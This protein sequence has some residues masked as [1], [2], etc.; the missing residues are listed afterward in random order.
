MLCMNAVNANT[1]K[2]RSKSEAV[3]VGENAPLHV[4]TID[5][6]WTRRSPDF[7]GYDCRR[8][9]RN[10]E[11]YDLLRPKSGYDC[12]SGMALLRDFGLDS[13]IRYFPYLQ[14]HSYSERENT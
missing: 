7:R 5:R 14:I 6:Q 13:C 11:W 1:A 9:R 10:G 2:L 4:R 3:R 8:C 12:D